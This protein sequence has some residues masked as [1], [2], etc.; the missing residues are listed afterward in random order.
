MPFAS[1]PMPATC[2]VHNL[3]SLVH[4]SGNWRG[5]QAMKL[6]STQFSPPSSY[7]SPLSENVFSILFSNAL[8]LCSSLNVKETK[9]HIHTKQLDVYSFSANCLVPMHSR[10]QWV[11]GT[12]CPGIK[13]PGRETANLLVPKLERMEVYLHFYICHRGV[14]ID[15]FTFTYRL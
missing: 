7:S 9:F 12:F 15:Y 6:L 1:L 3:T 13:R 14:Y 11:P 5:V 10:F 2:L 4:C 8:S